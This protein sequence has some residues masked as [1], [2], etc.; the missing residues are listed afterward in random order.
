[1]NL[2]CNRIGDNLDFH[3][4]GR[5][6]LPLLILSVSRFLSGGE[7][8]LGPNNHGIKKSYSLHS[9]CQ[10]ASCNLYTS[11]AFK[12]PMVFL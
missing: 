10:W 4:F 12:T 2:Q 6:S 11:Y 1:M 8:D 9:R 5:L 3:S 7:I